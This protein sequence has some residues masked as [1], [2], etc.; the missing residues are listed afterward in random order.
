MNHY[1]KAFRS[2]PIMKGPKKKAANQ[3]GTES[4]LSDDNDLGDDESEGT[5]H[6]ITIVEPSPGHIRR[7]TRCEVSVDRQTLI[8]LIDTEP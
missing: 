2:T 3:V 6:V 1:S 5:I 8:M 4:V 7:A